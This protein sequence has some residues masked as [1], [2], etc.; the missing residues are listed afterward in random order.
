VARMAILLSRKKGAQKTGQD[1]IIHVGYYLI[2]QG[3]PEL[4]HAVKI[5][6]SPYE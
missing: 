2:D 5:G 3:L 1:R 4:E 6:L